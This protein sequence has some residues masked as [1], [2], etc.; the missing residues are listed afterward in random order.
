M[1]DTGQN[2]QATGEFV[3]T[4]VSEALAEAMNVTCIDAPPGIDEVQLAKLDPAPSD[5]IKLPWVAASPVGSECVVHTSLS[6]GPDQVMVV[7]RIIQAHV[8]EA[9]VFD[10]ETC[11][12]PGRLPSHARKHLL[13]C[14]TTPGAETVVVRHRPSRLLTQFDVLACDSEVTIQQGIIGTLAASSSG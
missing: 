10:P 2:I 5:K 3:V 13:T 6:F 14:P 1:K 4:L 7:G 9:C 8:C 12:I 11:L